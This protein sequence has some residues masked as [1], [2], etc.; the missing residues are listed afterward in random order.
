MKKLII[1][2]I[3]VM[4]SGITTAQ[5][6]SSNKKMSPPDINYNTSDS[7]HQYR[8]KYNN[9]D[10]SQ[11]TDSL[12]KHRSLEKLGDGVMM[13]SGKMWIEENNQLSA[14]DRTI[15]LNNQTKVM[16]DGSY[17]KRDGTKMKFKE[18]E[19]MDMNGIITQIK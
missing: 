17:I 10:T 2:I 5:T 18:G 1:V 19:S 13:K 15:T 8:E 11:T 3:G 7:V 16:Q 6:D 9:Q 4:F 12:M 14:L